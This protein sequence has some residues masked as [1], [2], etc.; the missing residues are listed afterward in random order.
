MLSHPQFKNVFPQ[1]KQSFA[2]RTRCH[3]KRNDS[4]HCSP[5]RLEQSMKL[6]K[7]QQA[8]EAPR[9]PCEARNRWRKHVWRFQAMNT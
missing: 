9:K 5:P 2:R 6:R 1:S 7:P 8:R 4:G 3:C